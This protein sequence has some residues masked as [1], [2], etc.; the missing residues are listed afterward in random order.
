VTEARQRIRQLRRAGRHISFFAWLIKV[1]ADSVALHPAV[2]GFNDPG[3]RRV[4]LF[5]DVDVSIVVEKNVNGV[6]VPL[7]YVVR[8]ADRKTLGQIHQEIET[9][10]SE[11]VANEGQ[12]VLGGGYSAS[13]MKAF[14]ALP[15]WLR[16]ALMRAFVFNNPQRMKSMMGTVM[17]TTVGMIGHTRGWIVP[18]SMHP[19]GLAFGSLNEQPAVHGGT[20]QKREI[21]HLTVLIDHDVVDGMPA[22]RFVDALVKQMECGHGLDG[23]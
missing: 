21:L 23:F 13:L 19:L 17:M 3:R 10:K 1:T 8:R 5:E 12:Y 14:V 7:P 18:F 2:N 4:V 11:D 9:A 15:Q 16:L 20:I 22:A 6:P